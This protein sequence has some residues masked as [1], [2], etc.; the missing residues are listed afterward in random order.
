MYPKECQLRDDNGVV[1][2][3]S[4]T[5]LQKYIPN[6]KS[7]FKHDLEANKKEIAVS[8]PRYG[9]AIGSHLGKPIYESI[10]EEETRYTFDRLA[11]CDE[12]GC[13]LDQVKQNEL[14][15]NPGLIYK[16]AS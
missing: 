4:V 2:Q 13:P 5:V 3:R 12:E 7:C 8:K 16:K 6:T 9:R 1:G 11:K 15:V 14:L 10:Q